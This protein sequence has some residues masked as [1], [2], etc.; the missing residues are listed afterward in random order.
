MQCLFSCP[1]MILQTLHWNSAVWVLCLLDKSMPPSG[2]AWIINIFL[3]GNIVFGGWGL[4]PQVNIFSVLTYL[5]PSYVSNCDCQIVSYFRNDLLNKH[6]SA[7]VHPSC[8]FILKQCM[9]TLG[10]CTSTKFLAGKILII[11][12]DLHSMLTIQ[13]SH[14]NVLSNYLFPSCTVIASRHIPSCT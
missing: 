14:I 13:P 7:V 8:R 9:L 10:L 4:K 6:M 5:S 1:S 11:W 3:S 2:H 12:D